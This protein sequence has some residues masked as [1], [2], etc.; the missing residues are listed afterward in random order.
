[1]AD[2]PD[3]QERFAAVAMSIAGVNRRA[4]RREIRGDRTLR[5]L[6]LSDAPH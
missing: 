3:I 6:E 2:E 5:R 1:M 4:D